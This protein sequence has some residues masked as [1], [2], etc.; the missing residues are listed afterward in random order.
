[1]QSQTSVLEGLSYRDL[2]GFGTLVS[3]VVTKSW[4]RNIWG[5]VDDAPEVLKHLL[6][7]PDIKHLFR[8]YGMWV[9]GVCAVS[10]WLLWGQTRDPILQM[11]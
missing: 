6:T 9:R 10:C 7:G 2:H 5:P 1:M 8:L 3:A 11:G 4:P